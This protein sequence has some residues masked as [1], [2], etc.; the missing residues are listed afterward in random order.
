LDDPEIPNYDSAFH[1]LIGQASGNRLLA[2]FVAAVHAVTHPVEYLE[3][4]S[5]VARKTVKQHMAIVS[6]LEAGSPD[7]AAE[8]MET[9][10]DYV[11]R[12]SSHYPHPVPSQA[13][14]E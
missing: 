13:K 1:A 8:A 3:V 14:A 2:A 10:I 7:D 5:E 11:M 6:A 4:T 12:H 9:H